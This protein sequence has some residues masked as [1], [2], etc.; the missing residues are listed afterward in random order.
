MSGSCLIHMI[1]RLNSYSEI[2]GNHEIW[3]LSR[4]ISDCK[5]IEGSD[6]NDFWGT[7]VINGLKA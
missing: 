2:S 3:T 1:A 5:V 7:P 6:E 4:A